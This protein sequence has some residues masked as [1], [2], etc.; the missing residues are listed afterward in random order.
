MRRIIVV[1]ENHRTEMITTRLHT[2]WLLHI[3]QIYSPVF[4][5]LS[6]ETLGL[7]IKFN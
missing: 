2:I 5:L 7:L 6:L 3:E 4:L 1:C